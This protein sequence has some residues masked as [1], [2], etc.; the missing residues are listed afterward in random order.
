MTHAR[1]TLA[2]RDFTNLRYALSLNKMQFEVFYSELDEGEQKYLAS[3]LE[4]HRLDMLDYGL[5]RGDIPAPD[6][7]DIIERVK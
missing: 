3:L 6:I 4:T 2:P 1:S 7:K 5:S